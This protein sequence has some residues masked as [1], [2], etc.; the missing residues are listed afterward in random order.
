[1]SNDER[2][3][4]GTGC[5]RCYAKA[6]SHFCQA[7]M[8][9]SCLS[10]GRIG[11]EPLCLDCYD[12][13]PCPKDVDSTRELMSTAAAKW[14]KPSDMHL[15]RECRHPGCEVKIKDANKVGCCAKHYYW[16]SQHPLAPPIDLPPVTVEPCGSVDGDVDAPATP[17]P[18]EADSALENEPY[19]VTVTPK[20]EAPATRAQFTAVQIVKRSAHVKDSIGDYDSL[21]NMLYAAYEADPADHGMLIPSSARK[22]RQKTYAALRLRAKEKRLKVIAVRT[23]VEGEA[24]CYLEPAR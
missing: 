16:G 3:S 12:D 1:M 5:R 18:M 6:N 2:P 13:S 23:R 14:R 19:E 8:W 22:V 9:R 11:E 24:L 17:E 7:V 10:N 20:T 15:T 4:K 21:F